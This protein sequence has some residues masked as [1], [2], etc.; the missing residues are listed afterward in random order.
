MHKVSNTYMKIV[1]LCLDKLKEEGYTD[2]FE[3]ANDHRLVNTHS[4]KSYPP[5]RIKVINFLSFDGYSDPA[6]N[7]ILYIL[8]TNDGSKGTLVD[9]FGKKPRLRLTGS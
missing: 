9:V 5:E 1:A 8:E 3:V 7:A 2:E 6:D 4:H